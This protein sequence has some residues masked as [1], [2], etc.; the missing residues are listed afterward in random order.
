MTNAI[1][2]RILAVVFA[3][4]MLAASFWPYMIPYTVTVW[5]AAAL[6]QSLELLFWGGDLVVFPVALIY[7]GAVF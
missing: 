1:V 6:P 5:D 2:R 3:F 7:T 4:L